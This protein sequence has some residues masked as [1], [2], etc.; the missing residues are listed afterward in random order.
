MKRVFLTYLLATLACTTY[1]QAVPVVYGIIDVGV[2]SYKEGSTR[3][4]R[5]ANG[6]LA[7][8]R[9]GI[10]GTEDLGQGLKVSFQLEGQLNPASGSVGSSSVA[11]NELFNRESWVGLSSVKYGEIRMGR[12]DV[13]NSSEMDSFVWQS[14]NFSLLPVNMSST[15]QGADQ[16]NVIKYIS[17]MMYGFTVQ[18]GR[19][20]DAPGSTSS[21]N[22]TQKAI[23]VNYVHG[24][25]KGGIGRHVTDGHSSS[26]KNS[27]SVSMAHDFGVV[28]VGIAH[29]SGDNSDTSDISSSAKVISVKIP[30]TS[31]T[32]VHAVYGV[33]KSALVSENNRSYGYTLVFTKDLS[34]R[35]T[36]Y[37]AYTVVNNDAGARMAMSGVSAPALAGNDT[38]AIGIGIKHS[39]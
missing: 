37:S 9:L 16:K 18:L 3:T 33:S 25:F 26:G 39:F 29:V 6:L 1:A 15:E 5:A 34:K 12:T 10:K 11:A 7:T 24:A 4:T 30:T 8:S 14:G 38:S 22:A 21:A 36:L 13:S 31:S 28:S 32:A 20:S 27:T 35:T 17:P 23:S 19:V 2:Q